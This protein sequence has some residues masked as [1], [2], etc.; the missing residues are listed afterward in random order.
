MGAVAGRDTVCFRGAWYSTVA[1]ARQA[2]DVA[3]GLI[4]V[5]MGTSQRSVTTRR[6][7]GRLPLPG[8]SQLSR[9]PNEAGSCRRDQ[10]PKCHC[11]SAAAAVQPRGQRTC[12]S[13]CEGWEAPEQN[14]GNTGHGGWLPPRPVSPLSLRDQTAYSITEL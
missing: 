6:L 5:Q 12:H 7:A 11:D 14:W 1:G 10:R 9:L 13:L 8:I 4:S 2:D 3:E